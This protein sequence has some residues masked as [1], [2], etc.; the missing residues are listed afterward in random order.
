MKI[1]DNEIYEILR[2]LQND[3][4]KSEQSFFNICKFTVPDINPGNVSSKLLWDQYILFDDKSKTFSVIEDGHKF[5][6]QHECKL[7][8]I[9]INEYTQFLK[10][11]VWI[12][13]FIISIVANIFYVLKYYR[14]F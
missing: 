13:A 12:I 4:T 1:S 9:T 10:S 8:R 7:I 11:L 14:I 2:N 5:M 6:K 3:R